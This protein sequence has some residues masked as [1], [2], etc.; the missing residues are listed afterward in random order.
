MQEDGGREAEDEG[1]RFLPQVL[2]TPSCIQPCQSQHASDLPT[3]G[4]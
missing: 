1:D 4:S 3:S 2:M